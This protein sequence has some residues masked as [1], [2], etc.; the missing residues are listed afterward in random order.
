VKLSVV[1]T[2]YR[3]ERFLERYLEEMLAT[4]AEANCTSFE[5][6]FVNDGSPDS[7]VGYL[8]K[9]QA[10]IKEIRILDLSRNFGHHYAIMAGLNYASGDLVFLIDC[11]LE[12]NPRA[13]LEFMTRMDDD[14][15][16]VYG[17][18][19][20][21]VG[22]FVSR[23]FGRVFWSM[24]NKL[25]EISIPENV[26]TERLMKKAYVENLL[27]MGDRNVFLAGMMYWVGYKQIGIPIEK[28]PRE[29]RSTYTIRKRINLM[30][31]AVTSFSAYPLRLLFMIGGIVTFLS[32]TF[33][34]L[35][36]LRKV[37]FPHSLLTGYPSLIAAILF[38]LGLI[39][40][41]IGTVGM[42]IARIFK[43]V[44]NRPNYIIKNIYK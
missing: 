44:Q 22:G 33:G 30:M 32:I 1:T 13:L 23:K 2:L 15:D 10:E 5:L 16:V 34:C 42:Y 29:G 6:I 7:S 31:E 8:L 27:K 38:S 40:L 24:M 20:Q 37:F 35:I 19:E 39:M 17:Y 41:S 9:R 18:S 25:G 12:V 26:L 21:R 4:L 11:D 36:I 28:K 14:I 43:Q 3:S